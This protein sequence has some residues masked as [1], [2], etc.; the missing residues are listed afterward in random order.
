MLDRRPSNH[1]NWPVRL[2]KEEFMGYCFD[3][4]EA[5]KTIDKINAYW[6]WR[7]YRDIVQLNSQFDFQLDDEYPLNLQHC[8]DILNYSI[9][10][11][12]EPG[13]IKWHEDLIDEANR[14]RTKLSD[15]YKVTSVYDDTV[16][17]NK[18]VYEDLATVYG[19]KELNS[20][21]NLQRIGDVEKIIRKLV[22]TGYTR[23]EA[24]VAFA[25]GAE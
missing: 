25:L 22:R 7:Y 24:L 10:S 15:A 2:S 13:E 20:L 4:N 19:D 5:L 12:T 14:D 17:D 11:Q 9:K 3:L 23:Q 16:K 18:E 8:L 1:K 21:R 6:S